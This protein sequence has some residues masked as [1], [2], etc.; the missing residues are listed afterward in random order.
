V[1]LSRSPRES[2]L[3]KPQVAYRLRRNNNTDTPLP[4]ETPAGKNPPDGAI[5]DYYLD[6]DATAPVTLE[7]VTASGA[8]V[9]RYTSEDKPDPLDEK[10]INVP[11]YWVRPPQTLSAA[12]GMHR[13]IWD[14]RYPAP[15]AV[16]RDYPISAIYRDTPREP[17]GVFAV[18]GA[19]TMKLTAG[20]KTYT[21]PLTLKMDPRATITP[22]GLS[23]QFTLAKKI[24]DMMGQS[25][26][27]ISNLS[28]PHSGTSNTQQPGS[29]IRSDLISLNNDLATAYDVVEGADRAPTVQA[30][31]AVAN[32]ERRFTAL[33]KGRP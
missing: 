10:E 29:S 24:V 30:T 7:I 13:F 17:L 23:K 27:A 32:L 16:Q 11:T 33:M 19:Y 31:K 9:R 5:I 4:P 14:L 28:S 6:A 22:L 20:G 18:P 15:G 8:L 26:V 25:F 2:F 12:R 3:Y 21:Q 1:S